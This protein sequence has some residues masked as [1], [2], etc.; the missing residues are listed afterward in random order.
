LTLS[1]HVVDNDNV[2]GGVQVQVH[3]KVKVK[4]N[5]WIRITRSQH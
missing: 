3:L 4:V 5:D 1:I 2:D